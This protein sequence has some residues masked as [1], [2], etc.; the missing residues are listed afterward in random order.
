MTSN[1]QVLC[2]AAA[3]TGCVHC[4]SFWGAFS[5]IRWSLLF[6]VPF[7]PLGRTE[8]ISVILQ[9]QPRHLHDS[10]RVRSQVGAGRCDLHR[11]G[12]LVLF[13]TSVAEERVSVSCRQHGHG[14]DAQ[15]QLVS[16]VAGPAPGADFG[17]RNSANKVP[18]SSPPSSANARAHAR[19]YTYRDTSRVLRI[20]GASR[21]K[22][23]LSTEMPLP[24]VRA[25]HV[26]CA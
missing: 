16:I 3:F 25:W 4:R 12:H 26:N 14:T 10:R 9:G 22:F 20:L 24:C 8:P 7:R 23:M 2:A 1:G 15:V 5:H 19:K 21:F 17:P 18:L 13:L 6:S 11:C